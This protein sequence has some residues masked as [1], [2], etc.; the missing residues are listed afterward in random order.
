M[1][2]AGGYLVD[3]DATGECQFCA[4]AD[5]NSL[6]DQLS[7]SYSNRWRNFGILQVRYTLMAAVST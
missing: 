2:L 5:T 4:V 1:A 6:L 7:S 3:K